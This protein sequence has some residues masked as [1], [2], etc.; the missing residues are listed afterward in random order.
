MESRTVWR[1]TFGDS[2]PAEIARESATL[3]DGGLLGGH[4]ET[5][6]EAWGGILAAI[7]SDLEIAVAEHQ[8]C[9]AN[10]G[11]ARRE[12]VRRRLDYQRAVNAFDVWRRAEAARMALAV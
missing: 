11:Y 5:E 6:L 9:L 3:P 8:R 1:G 7:D 10:C 2:R 12:L 4:W